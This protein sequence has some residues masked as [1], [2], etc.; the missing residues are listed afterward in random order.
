MG[1]NK[2]VQS[3]EILAE[4]ARRLKK[5]EPLEIRLRV[6]SN[7]PKDSRAIAFDCKLES[8]WKLVGYVVHEALDGVHYAIDKGLIV[9]VAFDWIRFI[10]HWSHSGPGWYCGI[11]ISRKG[12]WPKE[13]VQCS[14]T[15]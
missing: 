14:S 10:T 9:S 15:F 2:T 8:D 12:E 11:R 5:G 4:S 6:E 7:N 1:T 13:I 3:Q